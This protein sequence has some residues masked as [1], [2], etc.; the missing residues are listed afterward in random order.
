MA[1]KQRLQIKS[2]D[3]QTAK[4]LAV[5]GPGTPV[6][7]VD[8][9][10]GAVTFLDKAKGYYKGLIALVGSLLIV[11]NQVSPLLNFIPG[12]GKEYVSYAI[13]LLTVAG[14]FL[15]ENQHWVDDL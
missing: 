2:N 11:L 15:K 10:V 14:A 7:V 4:T 1:T 5:V 12:N 13:G 6:K 9:K 3:V 8:E